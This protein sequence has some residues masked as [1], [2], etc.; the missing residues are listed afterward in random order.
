MTGSILIVDD[1]PVQR[2]LLEAA[3]TR[4]GYSAIVVDGGAAALDILDGPGARE[5]SVVILDL[6]MPGLDGIG[7]LKAMRERDINVPAIV[8]TAQGG[9]ETVVSAM[10]HGAFDFVVKPAS[11]DRLQASIGN[12]LKVEAVEGEVKRT[13]RRRG[14]LLTFKDMITHSPAMDRVIRLGQKA[15]ASNIPILIEGESGVGKE[16]VARAIQGSGD[17]RTKP[18][19]TVNCGAIPDNLVESILFGHEK[20]SFTGATDK[21]TGKFVEAHSGT[22][23]LD[24][25]GDLPLDVQVKLLRAVQDGEVDPVGGRSTVRVDIRLISATHRNLLQQV[26]DGKFREDLFYRLNVYPI[27]V[28]PLRDRRDDIPYLV[29]HFME[30]VA[31]ADPHR[32]LQGISAAALAVLQAYDWPGNIRQ[33]ENAVFRASVLC[34]GYML[35]AEDFPQIRAQVEGTVNL[36]MDGDAPS[37]SLPLQARDDEAL[38]GEGGPAIAFDPPARLQPRFG[39]L[40]ALD[41]R[42]NVRALA[43]VELEM[44]KLA[45]DHYNG[46]MS[47]VARRLGI[48]RSTLYRKLKEHGIDPETGRVDRLAS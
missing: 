12:A 1:D 30:K 2:R 48:G 24:E 36:D 9:I 23:F 31:P 22:L 38:P 34:E 14:G 35:T 28:P 43:D 32:R 6:V 18:F 7:V 33:L 21:H 10:R 25:I 4:F 26:K 41:E 47:E 27:F 39:T 37:P 46:Q 3:V 40:R 29:T 45:I 8:Q 13:S 42:G 5:V 44:I 17:R 11:P 15:A 20:G 19:V 16:L